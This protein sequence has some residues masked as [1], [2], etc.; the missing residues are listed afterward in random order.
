MKKCFSLPFIAALA[1]P[2]AAFG[3]TKIG[4]VDMSRAFKE[5]GKTKEAEAKINA[6][7]DAAK[8][9]FDDHPTPS[10]NSM[11]AYVLLRLARLWGDAELERQ[12]S[13]TTHPIR[14]R[15]IQAA[16]AEIDKRLAQ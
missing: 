6:A 10:G 3:Q 1:L 11:L 5:Y 12:A 13:A 14:T 2:L 16:I 9:E 7:R 8:K 4:T 15:Q